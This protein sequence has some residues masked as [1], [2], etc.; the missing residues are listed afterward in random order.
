M[1][2]QLTYTVIMLLVVAVCTQTNVA[3]ASDLTRPQALKLL[4][5]FNFGSI[6]RDL[7]INTTAKY[8]I[9]N[10]EC[11]SLGNRPDDTQYMLNFT[12]S[13]DYLYE[14]LQLNGFITYKKNIM[15]P[16]NNPDNVDIS[17][18]CDS[19]TYYSYIIQPTPKLSKYIAYNNGD[20]NLLKIIIANYIIDKITGISKQSKTM[21]IVEFTIKPKQNLLTKYFRI[22]PNE[23]TEISKR[24]NF[25]LYDD[26]WR[27]VQ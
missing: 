6:T 5:K 27:V 16:E 17:R 21:A 9:G 25:Q 13:H 11:P 20:S 15:T 14:S 2:K 23:L 3:F 1:I 4:K 8:H 10:F 22:D 19:W 26:G 12:Q 7:S 24:A 18:H